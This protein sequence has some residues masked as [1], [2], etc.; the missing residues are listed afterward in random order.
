MQDKQNTQPTILTKMT[1][2]PDAPGGRGW[3]F[4]LSPVVVSA[5]LSGVMGACVAMYGV[6]CVTGAPMCVVFKEKSGRI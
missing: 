5:M 3:T 4:G 1:L 2:D 6:V